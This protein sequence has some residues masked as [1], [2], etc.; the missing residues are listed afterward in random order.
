[1]YAESNTVGVCQLPS[2]SV[3]QHLEGVCRLVNQS[4]FGGWDGVATGEVRR[5]EGGSEGG[6]EEVSELGAGR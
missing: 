1:M 2:Q 5:G 4:A 6:S 3:S